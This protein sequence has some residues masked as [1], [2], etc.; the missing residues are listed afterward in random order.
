LACSE[1]HYPIVQYFIENGFFEEIQYRDR[2]DN[3]PLEDAIRVKNRSIIKY[4]KKKLL[5]RGIDF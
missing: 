5:E 4:L 1:G 3:T 2:W